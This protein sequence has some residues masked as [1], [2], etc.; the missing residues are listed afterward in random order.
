MICSF[1]A[2]MRFTDGL[3]SASA[4]EV[5]LSRVCASSRSISLKSRATSSL[6]CA[7]GRVR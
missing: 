4:M 2:M 6:I 7:A 5:T 3:M 1:L